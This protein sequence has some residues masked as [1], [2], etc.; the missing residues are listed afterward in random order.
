MRQI[1][2]KTKSGTELYLNEDNIEH[3]TAS[4]PCQIRMTSGNVYESDTPYFVIKGQMETN[5]SQNRG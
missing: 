2:I 5:A 1:H 4:G 3:I